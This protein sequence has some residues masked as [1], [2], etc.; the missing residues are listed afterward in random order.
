LF[1][2]FLFVTFS[3]ARV[4]FTGMNALRKLV[5]FA[6]MLAAASAMAQEP[7][8]KTVFI[9]GYVLDSLD[10][11]PVG[12]VAMQLVKM[13]GDS[14]TWTRESVSNRYGQFSF[15]LVV[16][17]KQIVRPADFKFAA[18]HSGYTLSR[19]DMPE[20]PIRTAT[21][22]AFRGTIYL[23]P[24]RPK[25]AP[26]NTISEKAAD[27]RFAGIV[28]DS[29]NSKPLQGAQ[30]KIF[31]G[32]KLLLDTR[33]PEDGA[34]VSGKV[35]LTPSQADS[36]TMEVTARFYRTGKIKKQFRSF[37]GKGNRYFPE[38]KPVINFTALLSDERNGVQL[39]PVD[40][41]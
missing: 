38:E 22:E 40:E 3:P 39:I 20:T 24:G 5:F 23:T 30:V 33:T 16:P 7:G 8:M 12:N 37:N 41:K 10:S 26:V 17:E 11:K 4:I 21:Y 31:L 27:V 6:A 15:Q 14:V 18:V 36:L 32:T 34:F 28:I 35:R 13:D 19:I 1:T 9:D 2:A 25:P 29:L